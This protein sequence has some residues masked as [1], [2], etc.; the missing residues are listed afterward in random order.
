VK[1][2]GETLIEG[3]GLTLVGAGGA[4]LLDRVD[5]GVGAGEIL[6]LIGPNG[7]GKTT[8][9]RVLLGL[10]RPSAGEVRRRAG[11]RIGYMPQR[12][13]VDPVLPMDVD[14]FLALA[15]SAASLEKR[16][17]ALRD[18]GMGRLAARPMHALSGGELQRV[19]MAR[20]LVHDPDLLVLDEPAQGVDVHGQ[21]EMYD[22]IDR[23]RRGRGCGVILVSHDLHVV[24]ARTDRVLCLNRH[25]CCAGRPET[26]SRHPE[27]LALFGAEAASFAVYTHDH[28]HAHDSHGAVVPAGA[29]GGGHEG[30]DHA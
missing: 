13:A 28:D 30:H 3:R 18:V 21:S 19:L 16:G 11:L 20:A 7:A 14:R 12:L 6:S 26:V 5:V 4:L 27:Y 2:G 29:Q 24:M 15:G 22:L 23:L 25:V 1:N 17:Q 10:I 8:L 9:L